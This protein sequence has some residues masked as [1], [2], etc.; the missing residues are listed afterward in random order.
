MGKHLD[1]GGCT[2]RPPGYIHWPPTQTDSHHFT[3]EGLDQY[4]S[5]IEGRNKGK[6]LSTLPLNSDS[7][8]F[9]CFKSG[10]SIPMTLLEYAV[11]INKSVSQ[12]PRY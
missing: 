8:I 1:W 3:F 6:Y 5:I 7:F 4:D 11:W 9:C 10:S 12:P 2:T